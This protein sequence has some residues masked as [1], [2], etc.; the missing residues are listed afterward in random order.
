M[1]PPPPITIDY[2]PYKY[3]KEFHLSP[4]RFHLI[5][6]G[7]RVGK[8]KSA[9]QDMLKHCLETPKAMAWWVAP[10]YSM[11]REIGWAEFKEYEEV[12]KPAIATSHETLLRVRFTNKSTMYFKGADNE[13]SLRG[14][15]LT[16]LVM[17]EAAFIEEEVW[18]KALYPALTDRKGKALL[19]STPNGRN[20][21]WE[22]YQAAQKSRAWQVRKWPTRMNP[23]ISDE[24]YEQY[25]SEVD[26]MTYRQ[27]FLAEFVTQQGMVYDD[28][29]EANIIDPINVDPLS[30][31]MLGVDFGFANPTAIGFFTYDS[32][33]DIVIQFDE[34]YVARKS[35]EEIRDMIYDKLQH[36]K[37]KLSSVDYVYTDPAGNAEELS[38]GISPVDYL[39]ANGFHVRNRGTEIAPGLALVRSYIKTAD[40]QRRYFVTRNCKET[41]RSLYGYT[42]EKK[43]R[44]TQTVKEEAAK[45]GIHDHMA[46]AIRYFFVNQFQQ[47]YWGT[48]SPTRFSYGKDEEVSTKTWKIC[49]DCS[50]R[51]LSSTPANEPPYNCKDCD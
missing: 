13:R 4:S 8:S 42:Y 30:S 29:T 3:Q 20:W 46:D 36:H 17:D 47:N 22:R 50:V 14:R 31:V 45:D 11:A 23:L 25:K 37:L 48:E 28:F 10:T 5:V 16:Y 41:I 1:P 6:G 12:L 38:S 15:G 9:F 34:I 24:D 33:K 19:I 18:R 32:N 40:G 21:Y 43:S 7:R 49:P 35:I 26:D 44:N 51:F 2:V 39:R 27:E